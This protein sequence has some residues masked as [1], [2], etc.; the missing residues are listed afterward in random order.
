[1]SRLRSRDSVASHDRFKKKFELPFALASDEDGKVCEAYGTWVED[2]THGLIWIPSPAIVGVGYRP[3]VAG[4]RRAEPH[5]YDGNHVVASAHARPRRRR[6]RAR[7]K[8]S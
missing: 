7:R 6:T 8:M 1:M 5:M 2:E 3:Y 4:G